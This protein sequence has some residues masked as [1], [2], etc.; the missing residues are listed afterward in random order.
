[1]AELTPAVASQL[2]LMAILAYGYLR[3]RAG[4]LRG[5]G[6]ALVAAT[7]IHYASVLALMIPVFVSEYPS[8]AASPLGAF[9]LANVAHAATGAV[10]M[11]LA[12]YISIRWIANGLNPRGCQGK[13]IMRVTILNWSASLLIGL[14]LHLTD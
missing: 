13:T 9:A 12:A 10:A 8:L 5:H 14:I 3:Y 4:D 7:V 1:M 11:V 2:L 6:Y